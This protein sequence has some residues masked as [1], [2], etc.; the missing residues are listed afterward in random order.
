MRKIFITIAST[1]LALLIGLTAACQAQSQNAKTP[2]PNMAPL[3]QY[4]MEK[5]A[6]ITL[7]RT[8]A[9]PSIAK[10]AGVMVL[11]KHGYETATPGTNGFVCM[12]QR[13]WAADFNDPNFWDA[14]L[15]APICFNPPAVR[16]YL[17]LLLKK[18][19]L[20]LAGGTKAQ[21]A[22][23]IAAAVSKKELPGMEIGAIGYML[24]KQSY[25]GAENGHWHP[26]LMFFVPLT[27]PTASGAGLPGSPLLSL[28]DDTCRVTAFL[29][30]VAKWS[31]G[32]PDHRSDN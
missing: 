8:A 11:G 7:A 24:S 17:Q 9:T 20:V 29:I 26:H 2:Y 10:D 30:P 32:T 1:S 18:T 28:N 6:E 3:E 12:V 22:E 13:S 15:R 27:D 19:D 5:N 25:L 31:D 23:T 4:L 14:K 21:M 16:T